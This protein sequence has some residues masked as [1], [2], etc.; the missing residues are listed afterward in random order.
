MR[1]A[2]VDF[3]L[4]P[5]W[6]AQ[7][8][9]CKPDDYHWI[10]RWHRNF[11]TANWLDAAQETPSNGLLA[12][13]RSQTRPTI[14]VTHGHGVDVILEVGAALGACPILGAFVV[15]PSPSPLLFPSVGEGLLAMDFPSVII[16][17]D[18]HPDFPQDDA[19][20]LASQLG[21]HFVAAG[22]T[23]RID[24]S[25]GQGPWPEGLMRLGWFLKRLKV[26]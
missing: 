5:E 22:P 11:A 24:S 14:L 26:H 21:G 25:S 13:A 17:P 20:R 1:I 4:I 6:L 3:I 2:D 18:N 7:P 23:Q 9:A 10:S 16:S 19:Q 12:Q 15:A 8:A